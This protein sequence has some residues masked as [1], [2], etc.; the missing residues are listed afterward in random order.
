MGTLGSLEVV[1]GWPGAEVFPPQQMVTQIRNVLDRY[2]A[3]GG[4]VDAE[5][6][7]SSGHGPMFD[8]VDRFREVFFGFLDS[9][10]S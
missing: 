9:V 4:R 7:E 3:D 1:P 8:A 5:W 6:F 2:R 10:S